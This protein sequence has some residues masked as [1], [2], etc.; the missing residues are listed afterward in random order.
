MPYKPWDK[1]TRIKKVD[2]ILDRYPLLIDKKEYRNREIFYKYIIDDEEYEKF[3]KAFEVAQTLKG[4]KWLKNWKLPYPP[5][6]WLYF[7]SRGWYFLKSSYSHRDKFNELKWDIYAKIVELA[8]TL[9]IYLKDER[10]YDF[11]KANIKPDDYRHGVY[12]IKDTIVGIMI[13]PSIRRK[14]VIFDGEKELVDGLRRWVST[15]DHFVKEAFYPCLRPSTEL[16]ESEA[17]QDEFALDMFTWVY[18]VIK[19]YYPLAV[20]WG[21]AFKNRDMKRVR[22]LT[23]EIRAFYEEY[24]KKTNSGNRLL[25]TYYYG[26][27]NMLIDYAE[28]LYKRG[29]YP[30]IDIDPNRDYVREYIE[31]L[32]TTKPRFTH[33][34]WKKLEVLLDLDLSADLLPYQVEKIIMNEVLKRYGKYTRS[35]GYGE[36]ELSLK[37]IK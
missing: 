3:V 12:E 26:L 25:V 37:D 23:N 28:V 32:L 17:R 31:H 2:E 24:I 7:V 29:I 9:R 33:E 35:Y 5:E 11:Q 27:A 18:P 15:L 8:S 30:E 34:G 4:A 1:E 16:F 14:I 13:T 19:K 22:K 20:E 21:L 10:D 36:R 6:L